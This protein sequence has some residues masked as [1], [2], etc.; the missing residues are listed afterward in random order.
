MTTVGLTGFGTYTP[1]ETITG[2]E[3]AEISGI[4]EE[5]VIE[6]MGVTSKHVCPPDEDHATDMCLAAARDALEMAELDPQEIDLVL[7]HGSEYKDCVV[8]SAAAAIAEEL[9][10]TN[11]YATERYALCASTPI[12]IRSTKAMLETGDIETALHVT[13]SREEDLIDYTNQDSSFMFNFGSGAAAYV[14]ERDPGTRT[15]LDVHASAAI[16]D[17]SFAQDVIMPAGGSRNP[18]THHTVDHDLHTLDVVDPDDMKQRLG[19]VSLP[20]FLAVTET[21]L[22]RSGF[23]ASDLDFVAITHMKRSFHDDVLEALNLDPAT[24]AFYLDTYGHVQSADQILALE[25]AIDRDL[26]RPGDLVSFTAA[27]TGYT[28]G[29]TALTYQPTTG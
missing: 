24:D 13:A 17:G 19:P 1:A 25:E 26:V 16:T 11:A 20:N 14:L 8:W 22:E 10:A 2:E 9:G 4:P 18:P 7:Y 5:V 21:A 28:W 27:G 6:K 15:M 3:I 12:A 29:A 23:T